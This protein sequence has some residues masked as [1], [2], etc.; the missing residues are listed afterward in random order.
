MTSN[1]EEKCSLIFR[2]VNAI[3]LVLAGCRSRNSGPFLNFLLERV[4]CP[5]S[6][7]AASLA[8]YVKIISAPARLMAKSTSIMILP[9]SIQP[10]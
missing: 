1:L 2:L 7:R 4:Y 3:T 10:F 9:S 6:R 5:L 8:K